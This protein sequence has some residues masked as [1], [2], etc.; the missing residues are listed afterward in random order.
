MMTSCL[1]SSSLLFQKH[2]QY[3]IS[4]F[5]KLLLEIMY[6]Q[7]FTFPL[8]SWGELKPEV[9][10]ILKRTNSTKSTCRIGS[11]LPPQRHLFHSLLHLRQQLTQHRPHRAHFQ[12]QWHSSVQHHPLLPSQII[13]S[14]LRTQ[15]RARYP[16]IV[17]HPPSSPS[18]SSPRSSPNST[19]CPSLP[20]P[21]PPVTLFP[22]PSPHPPTS[23]RDSCVCRCAPWEGRS[24][25]AAF[26]RRPTP[27]I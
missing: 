16:S 22:P 14:S 18:A 1:P 25:S 26:S 23:P 8:L 5:D 6:L 2:K 27:R 10:V 19:T 15:R 3:A 12:T 13:Q 21:S 9:T 11:A 20:T 17:L 4:P 24:V 7:L